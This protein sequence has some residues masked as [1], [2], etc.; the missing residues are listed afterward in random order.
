MVSVF[1]P[2]VEVAGAVA[3][4]FGEGTGGATGHGADR[5]ERGCFI[6]PTQQAI[7]VAEVSSVTYMKTWRRHR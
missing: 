4:R 5:Q 1:G 7:L 2:A 6:V 3:S